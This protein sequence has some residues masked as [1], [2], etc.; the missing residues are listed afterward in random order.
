MHQEGALRQRMMQA[1]SRLELSSCLAAT[2][3]DF[4][5]QHPGRCCEGT[6]QSLLKAC[7]VQKSC[8]MLC[9]YWNQQ[10]N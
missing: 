7:F 10:F 9:N 5:T 2:S 6:H 4:L 3:I 1:L 8:C